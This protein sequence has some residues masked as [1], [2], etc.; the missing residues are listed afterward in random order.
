MRA[1]ITNYRVEPRFH[2]PISFPDLLGD[3]QKLYPH[4]PSGHPDAAVDIDVRT[5]R[6]FL[7]HPAHALIYADD[8]KLALE[9]RGVLCSPVAWIGGY[10]DLKDLPGETGAERA[11]PEG[12]SI[13][14][15]HEREDL[16][17][18]VLRLDRLK[19]RC[20][21]LKSRLEEPIIPARRKEQVERGLAEARDAERDALLEL[22]DK[23]REY[24]YG[25]MLYMARDRDRLA[26]G[27]DLTELLLKIQRHNS[28]GGT[29]RT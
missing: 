21:D 4:Q 8:L 19:L 25:L 10:A 28:R 24:V 3:L 16:I 13:P 5:G 7:K 22:E 14:N 15:E 2:E 18:S 11:Y 27:K 26:E 23:P 1:R 12:L 17:S 29:R 20:A 6:V 9:E